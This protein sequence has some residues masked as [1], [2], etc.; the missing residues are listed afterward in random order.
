M[1]D[2]ARVHLAAHISRNQSCA[3]RPVK[4]VC[5]VCFG[6]AFVCQALL[7]GLSQR[8]RA[9]LRLKQL[10]NAAYTASL[11]SPVVS[12]RTSEP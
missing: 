9:E 1:P 5:V 6:H 2:V 3:L 12:G 8:R 7:H 11:S 10:V 4:S